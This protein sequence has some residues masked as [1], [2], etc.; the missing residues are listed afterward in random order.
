[1]V[2]FLLFIKHARTNITEL[3]MMGGYP[4]NYVY[5]TFDI[6]PSITI[7]VKMEC[8]IFDSLL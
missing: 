4:L 5:A 1:M 6:L 7:A 3:C 8:K 2:S